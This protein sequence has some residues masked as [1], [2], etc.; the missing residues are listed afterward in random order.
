MDELDGVRGVRSRVRAWWLVLL[1][2]MGAGAWAAPGHLELDGILRVKG[3][4]LSGARMLMVDHRGHCVVLSSSLDHFSLS[5]ELN[6]EYLLEFTRAGC[7]TKQVLVDTRVPTGDYV[8]REFGFPFQVTLVHMP[9]DQ[10]F[11]Y[12]GPVARV[13][14][15]A[16]LD[17]FGYDTDYTVKPMPTLMAALAK[18]RERLAAEAGASPSAGRPVAVVNAPRDTVAAP[19]SLATAPTVAPPPAPE[20]PGPETVKAPEPAPVPAPPRSPVVASP[21]PTPAPA[22][23]P[24]PRPTAITPARPSMPPAPKAV[25]QHRLDEVRTPASELPKPVVL[26]ADREEAVVVEHLRVTRI[27][28]VRHG[29]AVDEYRRVSHRYGQVMHFHNGAPCSQW[30]FEQAV[31]R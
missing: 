3:A 6:S 11:E 12:N 25:Q 15:V 4:D 8:F 26:D 22:P 28:R 1:L 13:H 29:D 10:L 16:A 19:V 24:A 27:V 23:A 18:E 5:L 20:P 31:G 21:A 17:D 30:E 2:C 14:F 9:K 7:P